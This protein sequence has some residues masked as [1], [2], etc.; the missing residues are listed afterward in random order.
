MI[1]SH[2]M[3][4][5]C[6]TLLCPALTTTFGQKSRTK[7]ETI[8]SSGKERSFLLHLPKGYSTKQKKLVPLVF[9]LHGRGG[10]PKLVASAYYGNWTKLADKEGFVVVFP[11]ALGTPAAWKGWGGKK[12]ED[13]KFLGTLIDHLIAEHR[14]DKNRVFMTGHSSGGYMSYCFGAAHAEK[15][16]AIGPVAGLLIDRLEIKAPLSVISFHGMED[17]VVAY[18]TVRGKDARYAGRRSAMQSAAAFAKHNGCVDPVRKD[19]DKGKTHI[20]TWA[21]GKNGTEVVLY[22]LEE[23]EHGW[24]RGGSRSVNA[25]KLIWKFFKDHPRKAAK[26]SAPNKTKKKAKAN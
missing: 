22:S 26:K 19:K 25:T 15:I 10:S 6:F 5:L 11:G 20:D 23:G 14:I 16:A 7:D 1:R 12:S 17:K 2:L 13:C 4:V 24:P 3:V 18:D 21:K 8:Q 9:M